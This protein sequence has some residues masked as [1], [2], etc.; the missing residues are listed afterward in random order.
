MSNSEHKLEPAEYRQFG[1]VS[2]AIVIILFGLLLP[3]LGMFD[4]PLWPWVFAAVL[5][6]WGLLLPATL[7][8]VYSAWMKFGSVMNWINTRLILGLAFF[9]IF[10]P[11]GLVMRLLGKDPMRRTLLADAGTYRIPSQASEKESM[12]RPY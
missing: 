11:F 10:M 6:V 12:E 3:F 4:Y 8:P 9:L 1:L 2:S 7:R 5:S